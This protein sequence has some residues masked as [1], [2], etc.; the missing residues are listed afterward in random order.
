MG[1]YQRQAFR[2]ARRRRRLGRRHRGQRLS[3]RER[4]RYR[5]DAAR[6]TVSVTTTDSNLS[7]P[8]SGWEY[9]LTPTPDGSELHVRAIRRSEEPARPGSSS[10]C[11]AHSARSSAAGQLLARAGRR[12]VAPLAFLADNDARASTRTQFAWM[13]HNGPDSKVYPEGGAGGSALVTVMRVLG[14]MANG[15]EC[16]AAIVEPGWQWAGCVTRTRVPLLSHLAR[17]T[18]ARM[19][20]RHCP[21]GPV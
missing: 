4:E 3:R 12:R 11:Y 9:R 21:S 20:T 17:D 2:G 7:G 5:W 18:F 19:H 6:G 15:S 14:T 16:A 10:C 13:H 1:W 8:G